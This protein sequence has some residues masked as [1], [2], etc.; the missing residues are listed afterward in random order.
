MVSVSQPS[1]LSLG[2]QVYERK[3]SGKEMWSASTCVFR[4]KGG[5][6]GGTVVVGNHYSGWWVG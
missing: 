1:R 4:D 3:P 6:M 5:G 2:S